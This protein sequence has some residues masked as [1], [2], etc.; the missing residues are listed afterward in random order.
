M[1]L[2]DLP[3]GTIWRHT[4][5]ELPYRWF[6]VVDAQLMK[7]QLK[8]GSFWEGRTTSMDMKSFALVHSTPE[9]TDFVVWDGKESLE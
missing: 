7:T 3:Y 6:M 8:H 4:S 9:A 5:D 2:K 1:M